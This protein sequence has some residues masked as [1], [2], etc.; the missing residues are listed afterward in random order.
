MYVHTCHTMRRAEQALF[1]SGAVSSAQLMEIAIEQ[2]AA[3]LSLDAEFCDAA[4]R[5]PL[6]VVYA[7]KGKNAG[8]AIG[9][10]RA[11]GFQR[12]ILRSPIATADFAPETQAQ[13]ERLDR[14]SL[15]L[16]P[17]LPPLPPTGALLI[18]GLLGSGACGEL[19]S[20]YAALVEE[21]NRVRAEHAYCCT[22]AVDIP[23][24]LS[25]DVGVVHKTIVQADATLAI[26]CV[27]PGML[28]DGAEDYVGRLICVP[29]PDVPLPE[30]AEQVTDAS[31]DTWTP[32]R[33]Y[34]DYKN[35]MGRVRIVAGSLGY[36]GAAHMCAEA[37]LAAGAGLVE[38]CCLPSIYPLLASRVAAE[39]MVRPVS[40]FREVSAAG[41]DALLIGPGLGTPD[42][43]DIEALQQLVETA[44]CPLVLDADGLNLAAA[45][46]WKLPPQ[47]ILT[48]HPGEMRRLFPE[49]AS[50]S[51][52]ACA[53]A[54]IRRQ[55]TP[56]TLLLKGARSIITDGVRTYYNSTG[57]PYMA[58]GGQGDVLSGVIAAGA[59]RGLEPLQAAA[60]GAYLCGRAAT[61]ARVHRGYPEAVSATQL[62]P[63]LT[64]LYE[65][66]PAASGAAPAPREPKF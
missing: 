51:R 20:E 33:A 10:A 11:M 59:A 43:Q 2:A 21:M 31:S 25:A 55:A 50:M 65:A 14:G 48:P 18:D 42:A 34:S 37:A 60:R 28:A 47:A 32:R 62:L 4:R 19:R 22:L 45:H 41:A 40:S 56:C 44:P 12:I 52:A 46:G 5:F 30:S 57:G 39:V 53:A 35:K 15:V 13:L 26:G 27:K 6:A 63:Y 66:D 58:N 49:G 38:L 61:R 29:L 54:F 64:A 23:T 9:L 1:D 24:G 17:E 36:T 7:G 16:S 8:D 3:Q